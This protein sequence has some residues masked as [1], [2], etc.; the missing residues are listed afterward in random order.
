MEDKLRQNAELVIAQFKK[1]GH[2]DFGY[3]SQSVGIIEEF[4]ERQRTRADYNQNLKDGL[5]STLGS[6][7]GQCIIECYGGAWANKDGQWWVMFD[8]ENGAAPFSKVSKQ[9]DNGIELGDSVKGLFDSIPAVFAPVTGKVNVKSKPWWK[10][11]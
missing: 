3:D 10:F 1:L 7:L 9:F 2:A 5:V 4:I 8:G 11:W 6:Y